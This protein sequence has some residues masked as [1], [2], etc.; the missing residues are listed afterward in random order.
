[1]PNRN[2]I[3]LLPVLIWGLAFGVLEAAYFAE[4]NQVL[5]FGMGHIAL[6]LLMTVAHTMLALA[7]TI[8]AYVISGRGR[9]RASAL[10]AGPLALGFLL[11]LSHYRDRIDTRPRSLEGTLITLA[12]I[13]FFLLLFFAGRALAAKSWRRARQ[14]VLFAG[15][16]LFLVAVIW[17]VSRQP[18]M[19]LDSSLRL[20][21][22]LDAGQTLDQ[23]TESVSAEMVGGAE[24]SGL[25][26]LF[27]PLDGG[28]WEVF[29]PMLAAGRL[30]TL[31]ALISQGISAD[32][33]S[34]IPTYSPIIWTS[35]ATGKYPTRHGIH[36]FIRTDLPLG[37][38]QMRCESIRLQ[39]LT[40]VLKKGSQ[41]WDMLGHQFP[42]LSSPVEIYSSNDIQ[43]RPVW[44]ILGEF[45]FASIVLEWY[46][47]QPARPIRGIQVSERFHLM[48]GIAADIP[49]IVYPDSIAPLLEA[50]V[51]APEELSD[52]RIFELI[53]TTGLDAQAKRTFAAENSI[54]FDTI[55]KNMARD[56]STAQ[57]AEAVFPRAPDWRFA[58]TYFRAMDALHHYTWMRRNS[59]NE[60]LEEHPERRFHDAIQRYYEFC[61]DIVAKLLQHA[62]ER[63]IVIVLSDHGFEDTYD[64]ELGP[65]GFFI[66]S[67]GPVRHNPTRQ[68]ISIYDIA[69]TLLALFGVPVPNDMDGQVAANMLPTAFWSEHP[70]R[71]VPSYERA[72]LRTKVDSTADMDEEVLDRLRALGYIR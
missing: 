9:R 36:G 33:E 41:F 20:R 30:P 53:D 66:I 18:D 69:P 45:G 25:R 8:V 2:T 16:S 28:T 61:D 32:L 23:P 35:I 27:I 55:R 44:D 60:D 52:E 26:V 34:D 64:H 49:N 6:A 62:D 72:D 51:V 63:T 46:I 3:S 70:I 71:R 19:R 67:G 14:S 5:P 65:D 57:L 21:M 11:S 58:A 50:A 54:W 10:V 37:L 40:K 56:I 29:D 42:S 59:S 43:A 12:I 4:A 48:K 39:A 7:A 31:Q 38:P 24:D 47:S 13:A 17:L 1:M 15:A 68:R 22:E